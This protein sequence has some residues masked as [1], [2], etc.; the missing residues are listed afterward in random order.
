V[1]PSGASVGTPRCAPIGMWIAH[2]S[3][4]LGRNRVQKAIQA[5]TRFSETP[6]KL[7]FVCPGSARSAG[8]LLLHGAA[9]LQQ[10]F[11]FGVVAFDMWL[12]SL[13]SRLLGRCR[14]SPQFPHLL[15][16]R[17]LPYPSFLPNNTS[18]PSF[19]PFTSSSSKQLH[20]L[21]PRRQTGSSLICST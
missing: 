16:F 7:S 6:T 14:P 8:W 10:S 1:G 19:S 11:R 13:T 4:G 17:A 3:A 20:L 5:L 15:S 2:F 21:I 12:G 9:Q 18:V